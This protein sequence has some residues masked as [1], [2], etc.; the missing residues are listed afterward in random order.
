MAA[1]MKLQSK[2]AQERQEEKRLDILLEPALPGSTTTIFGGLKSQKALLSTLQ[3]DQLGIK[4]KLIEIIESNDTNKPQLNDQIVQNSN[5]V[6]QQLL[7]NREENT[8]IEKSTSL[9]NNFERNAEASKVE[10]FDLPKSLAL[11]CDYASSNSHSS[12]GNDS[13]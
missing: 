13:E 11:V 2:T 1:L 8:P 5:F 3:P 10:L 4:R 12:S 7:N 6:P 9:C